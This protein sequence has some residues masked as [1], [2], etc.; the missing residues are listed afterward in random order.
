M[1]IKYLLDKNLLPD[2]QTQL[3]YH[4]PDLIVTLVGDLNAPAK[5]TLDPDILTWC[6][7]HRYILFTNNPRSM[8]IHLADHL[9]Q[10]RHIPGIFVFRPKFQMRQII[11]D[12]VVVAAVS[13]EQEYKDRIT[14][15]P[16]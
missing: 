5:G 13:F 2:Y 10:N 8:P 1:T 16:L 6:E 11:E 15:I 9:A 4:Q 14:Y 7:E 12:L 3:V